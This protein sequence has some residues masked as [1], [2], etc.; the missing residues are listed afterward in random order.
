VQAHRGAVATL[1]VIK[2]AFGPEAVVQSWI[3]AAAA[4]AATTAIGGGV[5][6]TSCLLL[7][8]IYGLID[9]FDEWVEYVSY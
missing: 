6:G 3:A 8:Q 4:A 2:L 9:I 5:D 7:H 1:Q